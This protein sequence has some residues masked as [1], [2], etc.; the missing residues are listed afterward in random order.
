M[1]ALTHAYQLPQSWSSRAIDLFL[2]KG[3]GLAL[4][5]LSSAYRRSRWARDRLSKIQVMRDIPYGP[6]GHWHTLDLYAPASYEAPPLELLNALSG[7]GVEGAN[8]ISE[9]KRFPFVLYLHGGGFRICSKE[10]HWPF[11]LRLAEEGFLT[12]VINYRLATHFPCPAALEDS[13]SSLHWLLDHSDTLGLDL[14]QGMIAGESAGGNLTLS[15][16]MCLMRASQEKWAHSIFERGWT[17]RMIAPACGFLD[18][19]GSGR[20][21][22]EMGSIPRSR[23]VS[24]AR[25]YLTLSRSPHLAEPLAELEGDQSLARDLPPTLITVGDRDPIIRD[26]IRLRDALQKRSLPHQ[27]V[28]YSGGI[29]SFHAA[30]HRSM[31]EQC[32]RDHFTFWRRYGGEDKS[33]ASNQKTRGSSR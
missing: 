33:S 27:L 14:T 16:T 30:I 17:P 19:C 13:V 24:L 22:D 29:H 1:S 28:V 12:F 32:W 25:S 11:G 10:T 5:G 20:R 2:S 15:T 6:L 3:S 7:G 23:L 18:V 9:R 8:T 21:A 31:A 4:K 26:S